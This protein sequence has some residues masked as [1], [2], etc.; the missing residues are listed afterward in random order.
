MIE[1]MS[2]RTAVR[3]IIMHGGKLLCVRLQPNK[4]APANGTFWCVP[5]GGLEDYEDLISG[6]ERE[7]IEETGVKPVVGDLLYIQQY[8][9]EKS[10][11]LEFLFEVKN[12]EQ[13]VNID[14]SKTTHGVQEIAEI[15]FVDP[16]SVN[17]LP[18]FLASA[19]LQ[20][21]IAQEKTKYF[22]NL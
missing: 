3:A 11:Y 20:D 16:V 18:K 5:G 13:Y 9:D 17:V 8:Q 6:L 10:E 1:H 12:A 15:S 4:D 7:M 21:D 19:T 2:R 14:L 22:N